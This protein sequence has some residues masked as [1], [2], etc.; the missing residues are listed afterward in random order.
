MRIIFKEDSMLNP[1]LSFFSEAVLYSKPKT[2][3]NNNLSS[4]AFAGY[5]VSYTIV[6][7]PFLFRRLAGGSPGFRFARYPRHLCLTMRLS[8]LLIA[9]VVYHT[10]ASPIR[11]NDETIL[12]DDG[13]WDGYPAP[14]QPGMDVNDFRCTKSNGLCCAG[15]DNSGDGVGGPDGETGP[16][17]FNCLSS[18]RLCFI[19]P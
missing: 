6:E 9:T 15:D 2:Q 16:V 1:F 19:L 4:I 10:V 14:P 13:T 12:F 3:S 7:T 5:A 17:L 8:T 11:E 18:M